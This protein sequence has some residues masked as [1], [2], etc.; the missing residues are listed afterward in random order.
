MSC[1][2]PIRI[3]RLQLPQGQLF[4]REVG[5]GPTLVFLHGSLQDGT[6]WLPVVEQLAGRFHCL[7]PDLLGF[8]E[9]EMP[10]KPQSIA[11][12][13]ECLAAYLNALHLEKVTLVAHSVGAWIATHYALTQSS[14]LQAPQLQGMVLLSPEGIL[15]E[16]FPNRWQQEKQLTA[17]LPLLPAGLKLAS[18]FA[19]L[20]GQHRAIAAQRAYRHRLLASPASCQLLFK[21]RW[22]ELQPELLNERLD[23]LRV[24]TR[25]L[26]GGN[27]DPAVIA[28]SKAY[29][30]FSPMAE[31]RML[32][33]GDAELLTHWSDSVAYE[34]ERFV[35]NAPATVV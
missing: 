34:I 19:R 11:L 8:G 32:K 2:T 7:I 1:P 9:S 13:A 35:I 28:L 14:Q 33:E 22:S 17:W 30:K 23:Q 29:A 24:K 5:E 27:D 10:E 20:V 3:S 16:A 21:R 18:P 12:Q 6:Q 4:W 26:Q 25:I 15:T 31:L